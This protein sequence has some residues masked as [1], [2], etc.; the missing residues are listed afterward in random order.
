MYWA[1]FISI[2][3]IG[4]SQLLP[5]FSHAN[6]TCGP[7]TKYHHHNDSCT[8]IETEDVIR[9]MHWLADP[10]KTS[11]KK[12][13]TIQG[14]AVCED[15]LPK[16]C[17]IWSLMS[18]PWCN[19]HGSLEFERY[20]SQRC[21][22]VIFHYVASFKGNTCAR[23]PGKW[24]DISPKLSLVR[25]DMTGN[26]CFVCFW[27]SGHMPPKQVVHVLKISE[28]HRPNTTTDDMDGVQYTFLSDML[29][30]F[31]ESQKMFEQIV[32]RATFTPFSMLDR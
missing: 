27:K 31:P 21:E 3:G 29:I 23:K 25:L 7:S 20:W 17:V 2:I 18:S 26:R 1:F 16:D 14:I 4:N 6:Q 22:V 10:P 24:N 15:N 30:H 19:D 32:V 8:S 13:T 28:R 9:A 5:S 11:C 12:T